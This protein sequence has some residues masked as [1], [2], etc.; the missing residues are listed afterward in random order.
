M[1]QVRPELPELIDHPLPVPAEQGIAV[2]VLIERERS[3]ASIQLQCG[4]GTPATGSPLG[5]GVDTAEGK[6][7]MFGEIGELAA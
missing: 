4:H 6:L 5:A 7:L 2:Q 1:N 3:P